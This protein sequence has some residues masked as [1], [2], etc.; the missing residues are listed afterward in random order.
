[1]ATSLSQAFVIDGATM[2]FAVSSNCGTGC[3]VPVIGWSLLKVMDAWMIRVVCAGLVCFP[4]V[5]I[6]MGFGLQFCSSSVKSRVICIFG[7]SIV[8]CAVSRIAE[9]FRRNARPAIGKDVLFI[10]MMS[11]TCNPEYQTSSCCCEGFLKFSVGILY[12]ERGV[13]A[14]PNMDVFDSFCIFPHTFR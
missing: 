11:R 5:S 9:C 1:M 2:S 14:F 12:F 13:G 3:T 8:P 4:A 10:R 6:V 7:K